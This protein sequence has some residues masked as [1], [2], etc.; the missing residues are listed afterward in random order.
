MALSS[1]RSDEAGV[2]HQIQ[3][4]LD[5]GMIIRS[6]SPMASP[7]VC[8]AKKQGGVRL[9]CNYRYVNSFTTADAFPL[10]TI[11]EMIRKVGQG[12]FISVFDAKSG[13]WQFKVRP[14]DQSLTAFVAVLMGPDAFWV[15]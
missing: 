6:D 11:N 4:L 2:E 8:V 12:R 3:E 15:T 13:Y 14:E 1:A 5:T 9:V 10:C 7:L